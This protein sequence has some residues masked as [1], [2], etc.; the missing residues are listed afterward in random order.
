MQLLD[1]VARAALQGFQPLD[2]DLAVPPGGRHTAINNPFKHGG[3]QT[4]GFALPLCPCADL[5]HLRDTSFQVLL[6][7]GQGLPGTNDLFAK[8]C[9]QICRVSVSPGG[10][11]EKH[12][13]KQ[14]P[15]VRVHGNL[16]L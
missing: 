5:R 4:A 3:A 6:H 11:D 8:K 16:P 9:A 2:A 15:L 1:A 12:K 7:L 14:P 10:S 13:P